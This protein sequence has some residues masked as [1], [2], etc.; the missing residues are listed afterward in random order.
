MDD[1]V[2]SKGMFSAF[3]DEG[4]GTCQISR[5]PVGYNATAPCDPS[6]PPANGARLLGFDYDRCYPTADPHPYS[7]FLRRAE[8]DADHVGDDVS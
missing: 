8:E 6:M 4:C 7:W 3:C 5:E 2:D 1:A